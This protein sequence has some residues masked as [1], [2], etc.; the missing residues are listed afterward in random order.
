MGLLIDLAVWIIFGAIVGWV[1]SWL[2]GTREGCVT[3]VVIGI[4]GAFIGGFVVHVLSPRGFYVV[5]P[6]FNVTS[7]IVA[8]IGAVILLALRGS[9]SRR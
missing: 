1:A 7:F 6:R 2:M 9:L 3:N 4:V 5:E 8:L